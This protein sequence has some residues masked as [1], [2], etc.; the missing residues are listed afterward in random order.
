[1]N[2][3]KKVIKKV[4]SVGLKYHYLTLKDIRNYFLL[5]EPEQQKKYLLLKMEKIKLIEKIDEQVDFH[6]NLKKFNSSDD[7]SLID[8][9][10]PLSHQ[11]GDISQKILII[12]KDKIDSDF[13]FIY[14]GNMQSQMYYLF[15]EIYPNPEQRKIIDSFTAQ[16]LELLYKGIVLGEHY[17]TK[18]G[19]DCGSVSAIYSCFEALKNKDEK[20]VE[21][22]EKWEKYFY[23]NNAPVK[24]RKS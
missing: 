22:I 24:E 14:D 15:T 3:N 6:I 5:K 10:M 9:L 8:E 2:V 7:S 4:M 21:R 13:D 17:Y 12:E 18:G 1:M 20:I 19:G 11:L 23:N 16:E